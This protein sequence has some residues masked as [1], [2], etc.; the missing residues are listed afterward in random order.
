MSCFTKYYYKSVPLV[1][2]GTKKIDPSCTCRYYSIAGAATK[3]NSGNRLR[4]H[5]CLD[6]SKCE[7][8]VILLFINLEIKYYFS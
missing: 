2:V 7:K 4:C 5:P 1:L 8:N 3:K 6:V